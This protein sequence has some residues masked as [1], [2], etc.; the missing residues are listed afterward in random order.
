[1]GAGGFLALRR[2]HARVPV[3]R[4]ALN[5]RLR[6]HRNVWSGLTTSQ[7]AFTLRRGE[8]PLLLNRERNNQSKRGWCAG[9]FEE[10]EWIY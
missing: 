5:K 10:I 1:V 8:N 9:G 7:L 2:C 4:A 3:E 6:Y